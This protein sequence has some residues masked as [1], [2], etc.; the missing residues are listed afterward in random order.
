MRRS[1]PDGMVVMRRWA[2][3]VL[4][5]ALLM[6]YMM[7]GVLVWGALGGREVNLMLPVQVGVFVAV[8]PAVALTGLFLPIRAFEVSAAQGLLGAR[9]DPLPGGGR[10]TWHE[11]RR[12]ALWFALHLG[13]GGLISGVTLA[14][15][16]FTLWTFTLPFAGDVAGLSG[17]GIEPGWGAAAW[18]V[19]GLAF[20][21]LL[22]ALVAGAGALLARLA[23]AL[24]G[25]S[26]GDRLAVAEEQ[27]RVLAE[28]NRLARELHDSVGH[29]L[30]VVTLQAAAAGRVLDR[31]PGTARAALAAI[32]ESA[33][34]ALEDLDQ[35]LGVLRADE[36]AGGG[37]DGRAPQATLADLDALVR[38]SGAQVRREVGDLSAVPAVVS[39]EA[40]RIVQ[41]AL[42]N[43]IKHGEGP[44]RLAAAVRDGLLEIDVCNRTTAHEPRPGGRGVAGMRERVRLLRG[45]LEA[46]AAEGE[47]RL[48]V[49]LPL[50][51]GT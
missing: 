35:V 9:I 1:F 5:G 20:L 16:P 23:P 10:R 32:E 6:P 17:L 25:P 28:R 48:S 8:L 41:E 15:I 36:R 7:V 18:P 39:R 45:S 13:V 37:A 49:R 47:W 38:T 12:T 51:S 4:G 44:V 22:T 26:A 30:S 46:G 40:Y 50:R 42:T 24:L 11:R 21:V 19:A 43:A 2:G 27:A 3:L 31:D 33:R 29:A 14:V 34:A